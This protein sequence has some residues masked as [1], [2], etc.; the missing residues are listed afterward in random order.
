MDV[1][2]KLV[3]LRREIGMPLEIMDVELEGLVPETMASAAPMPFLA[4]VPLDAPMRREVL[5]DLLRV[6]ARAFCT[7][8]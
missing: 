6:W 7:C 2:R 4:R 1:A 3:I 8:T 5:T